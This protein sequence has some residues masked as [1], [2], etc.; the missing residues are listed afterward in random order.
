[1][2]EIYIE[3]LHFIFAGV[4]TFDGEI[5]KYEKMCVPF[6]LVGYRLD[7]HVL[8]FN[9]KHSNRCDSIHGR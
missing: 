1:M 7:R 8:E 9:D 2:M 6:S 3:H 4:S 5:H